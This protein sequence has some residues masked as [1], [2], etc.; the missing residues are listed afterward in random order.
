ML[1]LLSAPGTSYLDNHAEQVTSPCHILGDVQRSLRYVTVLCEDM[2][3]DKYS[4]GHWEAY[5]PELLAPVQ[6]HTWNSTDRAECAKHTH[7]HMELSIAETGP[8]L[9][10]LE[11]SSSSGDILCPLMTSLVVWCPR[12]HWKMGLMGPGWLGPSSRELGFLHGS[13]GFPKA[14]K[15]KLTGL[16]KA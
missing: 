8:S 16:L 11:H 15:R 2:K 6:G 7:S 13:S 3:Q 10:A 9:P 1:S 12:G 4:P 14:P 5:C